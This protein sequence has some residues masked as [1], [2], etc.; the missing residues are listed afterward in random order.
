MRQSC[1]IRFG[2]FIFMNNLNTNRLTLDLGTIFETQV[3]GNKRF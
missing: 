3:V 2:Q 1:M